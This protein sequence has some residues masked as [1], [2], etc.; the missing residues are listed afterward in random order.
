MENHYKNLSHPFRSKFMVIEPA[1]Y[2]L[3]PWNFIAL[4]LEWEE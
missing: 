1:Q 3:G 4:R 2:F